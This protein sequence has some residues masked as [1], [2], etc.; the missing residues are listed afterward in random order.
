MEHPFSGILVR[1][2]MRQ[3]SS[4]PNPVPTDQDPTEKKLPFLP[5]P[6]DQLHVNLWEVRNP[7]VLD[8]GIMIAKWQDIEAIIV[9]LPW[10]ITLEHV[11]DLGSRLES[12]R[13]VAAIFNEIVQ[14]EGNEGQQYAQITFNPTDIHGDARDDKNNAQ[15][16]KLLRLQARAYS[17]ESI[18]LNRDVR[19]TRLKI[20]LPMAGRGIPASSDSVYLRFRIDKVPQSV[21]SSSFALADRNLLSSSTTT[22]VIDFRINVRRGIPDEILAFHDTLQFPKLEKIH[23]FL[24]IDRTQVCGFESQNFAG[25]RS[26]VD[27]KIWNDYLRTKPHERKAEAMKQFLGYQ[28]TASTKVDSTGSKKGVKDLVVLGRF[29]SHD[30][31]ILRTLRF[32]VLGLIFGMVGNGLWDVFKPVSGGY[33]SNLASQGNALM[34]L[35]GLLIVS[36]VCVLPW[37][38]AWLASVFGR[39]R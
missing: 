3:P 32:V 35:I 15:R 28:W 4:T 30:S 19:S 5:S 39:R 8:L 1:Y 10:V 25:C 6:P 22:R 12:E 7:S 27:E 37:S 9:D 17:I 31:N 29:S 20:K 16:F 33:L 23:F 26:L 36:I 34:V 24:T 2:A 38:R 14:Y 13:T 18:T 11:E 21:Y